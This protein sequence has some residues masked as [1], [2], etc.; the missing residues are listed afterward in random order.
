MNGRINIQGELEILRGKDWMIQRC[1]YSDRS[2]GNEC[3]L[4][5]GI[6]GKTVN[7]CAGESI[8]FDMIDD[9]TKIKEL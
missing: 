8:L 2:C 5:K 7:L 6:D 4:F 3:P 1:P 9:N